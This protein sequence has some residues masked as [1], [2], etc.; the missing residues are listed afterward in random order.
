MTIP[1]ALL[2]A[3]AASTTPRYS[4]QLTTD[5]DL[6][7]GAQRLRHAVLA[8][9]GSRNI[10]GFGLD[11]DRFDEHCV[12]VLI[13][14]NRS[15][16]LV[17][18]CRMLP[19]GGAI[20]AGEL[21]AAG[22]FELS[23]LDPLRLSMLE[24]GRA[25][26]RADH[27]NGAVVLMMW[28]SV[29]EYAYRYGYDHVFGCV[30][31]PVAETDGRS[32]LRTARNYLRRNHRAPDCYTVRPYRPVVVD[33]RCLSDLAPHREPE[34]PALMRGYL[35]SGARICGNPAYDPEFDVAH[36][37]TL[38]NTT[39]QTYRPATESALYT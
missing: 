22:S 26:V 1:T 6:V 35:R 4:V 36:F 37:P 12:H 5:P 21:C 39:G 13:R 30:S 32:R 23:A 15:G 29:L 25:V 33:G 11:A 20:A 9:E 10:S 31:M 14:D 19:A 38:L 16:E 27:R 34:L 8:D 7:D 28:S 3:P 2:S 18:C 17:A 24:F